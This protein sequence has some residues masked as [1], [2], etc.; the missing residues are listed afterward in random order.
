MLISYKI[1]ELLLDHALCKSRLTHQNFLVWLR[2]FSWQ[3][4]YLR[5]SHQHLEEFRFAHCA[6][7]PV[8]ER[9]KGGCYNGK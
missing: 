9:C 5:A 8:I 4:Y 7:R 3:T 1:P 2:W 6:Q